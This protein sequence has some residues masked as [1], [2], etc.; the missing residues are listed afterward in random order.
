M[1]IL[2]EPED[3]R[4][5]QNLSAGRTADGSAWAQLNV[6]CCWNASMVVLTTR[7]GS[8]AQ[9]FGSHPPDETLLWGF[10]FCNPLETESGHECASSAIFLP[11]PF[12]KQ[13]LAAYF[14]IPMKPLVMPSWKKWQV[15]LFRQSCLAIVLIGLSLLFVSANKIPQHIPKEKKDTSSEVSPYKELAS[16]VDTLLHEGQN[17]CSPANMKPAV[18]LWAQSEVGERLAALSVRLSPA[19]RAMGHL[20]L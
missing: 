10:Y 19:T 14:R 13:K 17:D 3:R 18:V 7:T 20:Q 15:M 11:P 4:R 6:M 16:E 1:F 5:Q 8:E 9:G 12:V 2:S